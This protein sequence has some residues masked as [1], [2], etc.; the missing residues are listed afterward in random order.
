MIHRIV[1]SV[2]ILS[3]WGSQ[4]GEAAEFDVIVRNGLVYDGSGSPGR[5][6]DIAIKGDKIAIIGELDNK[7]AI[8]DI[9]AKGQVV[10]PGFVNMLSWA[11]QSLVKDG[12]GLSD[13]RQG[14]TLEVFGE[15]TSMGPLTE[16]ERDRKQNLIN[17]QQ[18]PYKIA[19]TTFGE[20]LQYLEDK[21]VSPNVASFVGAT[22]LRINALGFEDRQ[23]NEQELQS[24]RQQ[25]RQ[26]MEEG[27]MGLGSSLIYAPAF[28][29]KTEELI[30][31]AKV[32]G[33]Y[34]GMYISH[35]RSEGNRLLESLDEL[36][37]IAREAGVAAEI[38]H[39]KASGKSNWNKMDEAYKKIEQARA[40]G[41]KITANMYTYPASS[42]GLNATMPP[43]VQEGGYNAWVKRLKDPDIRSKVLKEMRRNADDWTNNFY[44]A[45]P[46]AILLSYFQNPELRHYSG[47]TLAQVAKSRGTSPADTAIDLVIEDGTKVQSIYFLMSEDNIKKQLSYPWLSFGSDARTLDPVISKKLGTTHPRAY[48]N[49]V[50]VIGK[51]VRDKKILSM[52]EAVRKLTSLPTTNLKIP[53]RGLIKPGYFADV[54]IFDPDK[55]TDHAT[56]TD[57]HQLATGVNHVFVNGVQVLKDGIHTTATPG[58]FIK[59]PGYKGE[60]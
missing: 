60:Q 19:W 11:V 44:N 31:L 1:Y 43:W 51:Y 52:A 41:L 3:L 58:R 5:Q 24:M 32:V 9:D 40:A 16:A 27:A 59:G 47:K 6:I 33:E 55:V 15:G 35:M 7:T 38:Y 49:F 28:Y 8:T 46:D 26:A 18:F 56:F 13:I 21:G 10:T 37:T 23:P 48:G 36:I 14:V 54:V 25:A 2:V 53:L 12:R 4:P 45:G 17:K 57:P 34:D 22:T 29:S 42:T 39:L 30:A 20:Y 50:R